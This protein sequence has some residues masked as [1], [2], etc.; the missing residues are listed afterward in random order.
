M[1]QIHQN[2]RNT[3]SK[4][5]LLSLVSMTANVKYTLE[6]RRLTKLTLPVGWLRFILLAVQT[7]NLIS[8]LPTQTH[9]L[10]YFASR[11]SFSDTVTSC[12][13]T[14]VLLKLS[15]V[16]V[17]HFNLQ[18]LMLISPPNDIGYSYVTY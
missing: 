18:N 6:Q 15:K 12:R 7:D 17:L 10:H 13:K 9:Q 3:L 16:G 11:M 4:L 2:E 1:P 8:K 5:F 14:A